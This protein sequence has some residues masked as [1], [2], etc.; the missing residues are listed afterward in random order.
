M[1]T[2]HYFDLPAG[3]FF[4]TKNA[5]ATVVKR[6]PLSELILSAQDRQS[7]LK[8]KMDLHIELIA[9]TRWRAGNLSQSVGEPVAM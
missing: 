6:P 8:L 5:N 3:K 7:I 9:L 2:V 4:L 1:T